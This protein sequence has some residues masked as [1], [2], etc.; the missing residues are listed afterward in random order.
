M[1]RS[2][3]SGS[4]ASTFQWAINAMEASDWA[5]AAF[6]QYS[7]ALTVAQVQL[8]EAWLDNIYC[9]TS[10]SRCF[11]SPPPSPPTPPFPPHCEPAP[12]AGPRAGPRALPACRRR[13]AAE[14][15]LQRQRPSSCTRRPL[16]AA[17]A[18]SRR[19]TRP[20]YSALPVPVPAAAAPDTPCPLLL[21]PP[22]AQVRP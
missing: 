4:T 11:Y 21:P 18:G 15:L 7:A 1:Q 2:T 8:V 19:L 13:A 3:G 16:A 14:A 17:L 22:L 20:T 10:F 6:L 5:V 12:A 9:V